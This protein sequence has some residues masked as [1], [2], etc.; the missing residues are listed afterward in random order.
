[1][2]RTVSTLLFT[3]ILLVACAPEPAT[4]DHVI[5]GVPVGPISPYPDE[6]LEEYG[7]TILSNVYEGLVRQ[8][9]DLSF[10]PCLA[11]SW[12]TPDATTWV[13]RLRDRVQLHDGRT[14]S[15]NHIVNA[16]QR[17]REID[18]VESGGALMIR[19][20]TAPDDHTVIFETKATV[21]SVGAFSMG[22]A[23]ESEDSNPF[24]A[25]TGPYRFENL[26]ANPSIILSAF[27]EHWEGTPEIKKMEFRVIPDPEARRK[28]L[29]SGEIHLTPGVAPKMTED[30]QPT[31]ANVY[32]LSV[33][34][35]RVI[36]LGMQ[37][38]PESTVDGQS[39]PF[40]NVN[41]RHAVARAINRETLVTEA[42]AG[43]GEISNQLVVPGVFGYVPAQQIAP[44]D[45]TESRRLLAEAGFPL[46]TVYD[47][48]YPRGKYVNIADVA[49]A[50]AH[51]LAE[52]GIQVRPRARKM[53]NY[54]EPA[55]PLWLLGWITTSSAASAYNYLVHSKVEGLGRVNR[56]GYSNPEIDAW[57]TQAWN[58][59]PDDR[60]PKFQQITDALSRDLPL[61]PLYSQADRYGVSKGLL[62]TPRPDR[63][64][65]GTELRL[66]EQ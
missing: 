6:A 63:R 34:G 17:G 38:T 30:G 65:F 35:T 43:H 29:Q 60:I 16:Y 2:K 24:P 4:R 32:D 66:V 57:L 14:L 41:V 50:I 53:E 64:I 19:R 33:P 13:F 1:M 39:N 59:P 48:D 11:V 40:T 36:F 45:P 56:G 7:V 12:E 26:E 54:Y 15:A 52:V 8:R 62:F 51:D 37:C 42:L 20:L 55:A 46:D 28:L 61:L 58:L 9:S 27:A 49:E 18:K 25:G 44:Y 10:E 47:L 21:F 23:V 31:T 5:I 3:C 22:I